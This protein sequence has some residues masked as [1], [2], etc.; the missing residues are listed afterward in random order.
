MRGPEKATQKRYLDLNLETCESRG[1]GSGQ[2]NPGERGQCLS[3]TAGETGQGLC[4]S[5][6]Q[7]DRAVSEEESFLLV[8]G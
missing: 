5:L 4:A 7:V 1:Q 6:R 2:G 8:S 3:D